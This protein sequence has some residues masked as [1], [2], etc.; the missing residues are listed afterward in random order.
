MKQPM[1]LY[2]KQKKSSFLGLLYK[3][4]P[5]DDR[6]SHGETPHYHRRYS[7]SLLS[8]RWDQVGPECYGRQETGAR[9]IIS[10]VTC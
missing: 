10:R 8:S 2:F 9:D 6:L 3:K 4:N 5:G 1:D 7:V